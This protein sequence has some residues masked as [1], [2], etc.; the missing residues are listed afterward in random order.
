MSESSK[1]LV[2]NPNDP[3]RDNA[4]LKY[5]KESISKITADPT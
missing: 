2:R 3:R 5:D 4:I 1:P